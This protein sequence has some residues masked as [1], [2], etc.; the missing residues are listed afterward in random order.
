MDA[1][2][3]EHDMTMLLTHAF[4]IH[5][6]ELGKVISGWSKTLATDPVALK[7]VGLVVRCRQNM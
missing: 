1:A 7:L 4:I 5:L 2:K 3:T 6:S